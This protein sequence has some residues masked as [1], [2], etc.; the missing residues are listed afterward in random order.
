MPVCTKS[1]KILGPSVVF[2]RVAVGCGV[3]E[4]TVVGVKCSD[5]KGICVVVL[6][7]DLTSLELGDGG[8]FVPRV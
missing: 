8:C 3:Y 2:L 6:S 5:G 4:T 1:Q 7:L